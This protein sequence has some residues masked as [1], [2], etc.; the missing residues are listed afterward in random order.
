MKPLSLEFDRAVSS[1]D[2]L[3]APA[4]PETALLGRSNV[5]KSSLI[6]TVGR[7]RKLARMS[8]DPG[9]TRTLNFYQGDGLILV[10][11][12]GYGYAKAPEAERRRWGRLVEGY[13]ENRENLVAGLLVLDVRRVPGEQ[14]G[15]MRGWLARREVPFLAV[16]TKADKVSRGAALVAARTIR[17][18]L[19][20]TEEQ[21]L[22]F[23]AKTGAGREKLTGW[24]R[25]ASER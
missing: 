18:T 19:D 1:L 16:A 23:S 15:I 24:I 3:P 11:L 22:L 20:L 9:R 8:R 4:L 10:D 14:D 5:G 12:P 17:K 7:N 21:V 25:S 6:N 13:L 2:R